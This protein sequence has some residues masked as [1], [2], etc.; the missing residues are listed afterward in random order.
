MR[1]MNFGDRWVNRM[2]HYVRSVSFSTL[3]NGY[4]GDFL[5]PQRGLRQGDL[6]LPYLFVLCSE[7]LPSLLYKAQVNQMLS[8]LK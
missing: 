2:M 4:P 7:A 1:K 8:G 6:L 5:T 3:L